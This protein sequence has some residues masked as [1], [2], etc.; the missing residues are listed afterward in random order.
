[1]T[2]PSEE[3]QERAAQR[4]A[5]M[6]EAGLEGGHVLFR[7][8]ELERVEW[9][10]P[11]WRIDFSTLG[12]VEVCVPPPSAFASREEL[13]DACRLEIWDGLYRRGVSMKAQLPGWFE[14]VRDPATL[15]NMAGWLWDEEAEQEWRERI[16][17]EWPPLSAI[18]TNGGEA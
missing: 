18:P 3:V 1:M 12:D 15:R 8:D 16:D 5:L 17:A 6:A 13:V 2:K 7:G 14:N 11:T 10:K 4:L 9:F